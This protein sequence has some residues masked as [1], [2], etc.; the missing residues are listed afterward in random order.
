MRFNRLLVL[1]LALAAACP[2][3]G[4]DTHYTLHDYAP[5]WLNP[6]NTGSFSGTIRVGGI[7]RGQWYGLD[8][9]QLAYRVRRCYATLWYS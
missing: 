3:A 9:Y 2:A 5:L 6:A 8:W 4:Q 7:Y 1:F